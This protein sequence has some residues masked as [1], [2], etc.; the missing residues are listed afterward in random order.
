MQ[1]F[2]RFSVIF[3]VVASCCVALRAQTLD[4]TTID[5]LYYTAKV[6]GYMKYFHSEVAKGLYNWDSVLIQ[7]LPGVMNAGSDADFNTAMLSMIKKPGPTVRS[8]QP[9][10][11]IPESLKYNLDLTWINDSVFSTEVKDSL[12][13]I[14]TWIRKRT[15]AYL[16][17]AFT[18]GN[19]T[20]DKD[21]Q[22]FVEND[23]VLPGMNIRLL[24]LFRYWNCINYF[25]PYKNLVDKPWESVLKE[26]ITILYSVD[27]YS[28]YVRSMM[29]LRTRLNDAHAILFSQY[30]ASNYAYYLPLKLITID[31]NTVVAKVLDSSNIH[32]GD[33][34]LKINGVDIIAYRDSLKNII[35]GSNEASLNRNINTFMLRGKQNEKVTVLLET[36]DGVKET[37]LYRSA[38]ASD[39]YQALLK[40][41]PIW[42]TIPLPNGIVKIGYVDMERLT[43]GDIPAMYDSLK[44]TD[45]IIFDQRNY[46]QGTLWTLVR[47]LFSSPVHIAKFAVPDIQYPGVLYWHSEYIGSNFVQNPYNKKIIL[48]FNE[49]TQSQ[50]EY[51]IMGLEQYPQ[52]CKIGSQTAGADGNVSTIYLPGGLYTYFTGLGAFYPDY[53]ETQRKGII[54]NK[55]VYP[56]IQGIREGKDEVLEAAL[57]GIVGDVETNDVNI[58]PQKFTLFQNYPNPFNPSTVIGYQLPI[59][60]HVT[61]KIFD[62]LGRE[63]ATLVNEEKRAGSYE[64]EW[65]AAGFS[66]GV[67]FY[68]LQAGGY[69]Q[70]KKLIIEK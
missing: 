64:F 53:T 10:P 41:G 16:G 22:F 12:N 68:R 70:T 26:F 31:N 39:Y 65:N 51:T 56:T 38:F 40:P 14:K 27:T 5:R 55:F 1:L 69:L 47:Y 8:I 57:V 2:R 52:A 3:F 48:L 46:P 45:A 58:L 66:S 50:A 61:L 63:V 59:S 34:I 54:P 6:W 60:S 43:V 20:F 67:Y 49:E 32:P 13:A 35:Q 19:P 18:N 23:T 17:Q 36:K 28:T 42:K 62:I 44:N 7:T 4:S 24:G 15:N 29:R 9:P 33:V 11:V 21:K 37:D 25:F 30:F